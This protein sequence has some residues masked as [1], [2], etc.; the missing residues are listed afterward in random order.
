MERV[1]FDTRVCSL[2]GLG[3]IGGGREGGGFYAALFCRMAEM[4]VE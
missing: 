1:E 4:V 2:G 3:V